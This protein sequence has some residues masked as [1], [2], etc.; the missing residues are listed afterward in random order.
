MS[1][2]EN[3]LRM[4]VMVKVL[5]HLTTLAM[6][7]LMPSKVAQTQPMTTKTV[8]CERGEVPCLECSR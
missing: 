7:C 2:M 4:L 3:N 6:L 8:R 5:R 1:T